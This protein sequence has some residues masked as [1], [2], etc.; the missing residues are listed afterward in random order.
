[1]EH[2]Q[3]DPKIRDVIENVVRAHLDGRELDALELSVEDSY[4]G[5]QF[6]RAK[7]IYK[8]SPVPFDTEIPMRM[9][10]PLTDAVWAAGERR[11]VMLDNRFD[12]RQQ[13]KGFERGPRAA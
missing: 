9:R 11:H 6:I 12:K 13:I 3:V 2:E 8:Y 5:D 1:M 4:Y 7:V 10:L